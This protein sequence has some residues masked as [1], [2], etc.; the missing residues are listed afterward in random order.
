MDVQAISAFLQ[1]TALDPSDA[2]S[3][4]ELAASCANES[5]IA[6]AY[7]AIKRSTL[8]ESNESTTSQVA[9]AVLN[10]ISGNQD[11]AVAILQSIAF[12]GQIDHDWILRNRLGATLANAKR[13]DEALAIYDELLHHHGVDHPRI[14]YNRG[15]AFMSTDRYRG[16][17]PVLPASH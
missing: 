12:S 5:C 6:D 17:C 9:T 2:E 7:D 13:Y 8:L 11:R 3:W 4:V 15:I 16:S 1:A 14:H 10:S